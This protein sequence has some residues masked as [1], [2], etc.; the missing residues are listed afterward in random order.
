MLS[1]PPSISVSAF[2]CSCK[3]HKGIMSDYISQL[4]IEVLQALSLFPPLFPVFLRFCAYKRGG[5]GTRLHVFLQ[6]PWN[7]A[8]TCQRLFCP[9]SLGMR[10]SQHHP[11]WF[12]LVFF[13]PEPL[14]QSGNE[15]TVDYEHTNTMPKQKH[16][17]NISNLAQWS[18]CQPC[19][20]SQLQ[21]TTGVFLFM[22]C[23][24]TTPAQKRS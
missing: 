13:S 17:R 4:P 21:S 2:R 5:L 24:R 6:L 12:G 16:D 9:S 19:N 20:N 23:K 3:N 8:H 15:T 18:C 7:V 22:A 14:K 11:F 1:F 10:L